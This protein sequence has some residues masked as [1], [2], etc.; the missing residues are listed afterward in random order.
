MSLFGEVLVAGANYV[1]LGY[2]YKG[3]WSAGVNL[4]ADTSWLRLPEQGDLALRLSCYFV[5]GHLDRPVVSGGASV[6]F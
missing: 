4:M 6:A 2:C 3:P 5:G 1:D